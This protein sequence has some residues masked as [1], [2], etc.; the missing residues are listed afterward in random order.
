MVRE[1]EPL[2]GKIAGVNTKLLESQREASLKQITAHHKSV[3]EELERVSADENL[4]KECLQGFERL[5]SQVRGQDSLAHINQ[6]EADAIGQKDIA[7][8]QISEF[9]SKSKDEGGKKSE[10]S[11]GDTNPKTAFKKV[12][13]VQPKSM[14][15]QYLETQADVDAFIAELKDKLDGIIKEQGRI[16]I[17]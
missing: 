16:D 10:D 14:A 5:Q 17:R 1:I 3:Q 8:E 2:L 11:S 13:V 7:L 15:S 9:V 4:T 6:A 12:H